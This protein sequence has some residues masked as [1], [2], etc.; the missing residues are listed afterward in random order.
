MG[1]RQAS[2]P[3]AWASRALLTYLFFSLASHNLDA[4]EYGEIVVLW[5]AVFVTISV[6]YRPVEQL[7]SRTLADRIARG[8]DTGP[9]IRTAARIQLTVSIGLAVAILLLRDP[10]QD[11]LLSGSETLYWVLFASVVTFGA[12]FFARGL[13]R[14][15]APLHAP[16]RAPRHG[17]RGP[18]AVRARPCARHRRRA[19]GGRAGRCG[20]ADREPRARPAAG[21][22]AETGRAS[23]SRA[24][25]PDLP[26][27]RRRLRGR[28]AGDHGRRAGVPERRA[29][30]GAGVRGR[31][32][33]GLHLQHADGR[34]RSGPGLPGRLREPS[35]PP[36]P[37]AR[38]GRRGGVPRLD[39][40]DAHGRSP[41][42]PR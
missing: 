19:D 22:D 36:H 32:R 15:H 39:Q 2:C 38:A 23:R 34:P 16:G 4:T 10:L 30:P 29:A 25:A 17:V 8:D 7:L 41:A 12:S 6:A 24:L 13:P 9:A 20:G 42:S 31:G 11:G 14:R 26:R 40:G 33:G 28:R 5:S 37:H 21:A 3:R 1:A 35:P 27:R 18:G